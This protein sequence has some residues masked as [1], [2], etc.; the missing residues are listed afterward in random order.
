MIK[1][2]RDIDSR[3]VF[4]LMLIAIGIPIVNPIG[5]PFAI[6]TNT[7]VF[8]ENIDNLKPGDVVCMSFN[9][10]LAQKDECDPQAEI[11][12][13]HI[14]EHKKGI[15]LFTADFVA[16]GPLLSENNFDFLFDQGIGSDWEYG[17]DYA[18]LGFASGAENAIAAFADDIVKTFPRDRKGN[19]TADL[20][21]MQGVENAG[22]IDLMIHF[23]ATASHVP[24]VVRQVVIPHNTK[25]V[26]P[27]ASV[28]VLVNL[29]YVD[30]GQIA[31][32][33]DGLGGAGEYET[34][35]G[36]SGRGTSAMDAYTFGHLTIIFL[37]VAGNILYYLDPDRK[38]R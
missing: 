11:I 20:P 16:H 25:V 4:L 6:S 9:Y 23:T 17:E 34:I 35:Y 32:Y 7:R 27:L 31:A 3:F 10:S 24:Q 30:S 13:R 33:L 38:K 14:F 12:L 36:Y 2:I 29:P 1:K 19:N 21:L 5:T 8:Y 37:I 15:K 28:C 22:D 18:H 26:S